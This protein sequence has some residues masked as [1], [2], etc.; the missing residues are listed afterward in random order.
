M[1]HLLFKG[2]TGVEVLGELKLQ[3]RRAW[4][5]AG[6]GMPSRPSIA[7]RCPFCPN[8]LP[9][10]SCCPVEEAANVCPFQ[11]RSPSALFLLNDLPPRS[12]RLCWDFSAGNKSGPSVTGGIS[13]TIRHQIIPL[14]ALAS[15]RRKVILRKKRLLMTIASN[16]PLA[17][18]LPIWRCFC[19]DPSAVIAFYSEHNLKNT[20]KNAPALHVSC[21]CVFSLCVFSLLVDHNDGKWRQ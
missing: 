21:A 18:F 7:H 16:W 11:A 14:P 19:N 3:G 4:G 17:A 15:H 10:L 8:W 9:C 2:F 5:G 12:A 6:R 20:E 1:Q 13:K